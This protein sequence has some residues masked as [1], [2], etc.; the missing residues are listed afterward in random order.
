LSIRAYK[1]TKIIYS[2]SL[3]SQPCANFRW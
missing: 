3:F 1:K 2:G